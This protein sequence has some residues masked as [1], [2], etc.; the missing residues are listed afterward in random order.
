MPTITVSLCDRLPPKAELNALLIPYYELAVQRMRNMGFQIDLAA[1]QSALVEFWSKSDDYLHPNGCLAVAR[2][3]SGQL[4]GCAMMK[5]L[6]SSTGELKRDFVTDAARGQRIGQRLLEAREQVARS[7]GLARLVADT[8][9]PNVEMRNLYPKLGF[10]EV[11]GPI[12]TTTY[13]DQPM[14]RD[15]MHYYVK[16]L[17]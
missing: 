12:E 7:M 6:D 4:V 13:L 9:T 11:E 14:L 17:V 3:D 5:R 16:E 1:P 8:L 10:V 2:D 15:Y